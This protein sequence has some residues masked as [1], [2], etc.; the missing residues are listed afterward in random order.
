MS[1]NEKIEWLTCISIVITFILCIYIGISNMELFSDSPPT[2]LEI[3]LFGLLAFEIIVL[4]ISYIYKLINEKDK[5]I[6]LIWIV[7][8]I[9]AIVFSMVFENGIYSFNKEF[10]P[11]NVL[12]IILEIIMVLLYN[13]YFF[14]YFGKTRR[15]YV[16]LFTYNVAA[17]I[18]SVKTAG[19][20]Y[21]HHYY[22]AFFI[23]A[24]ILG[25]AE[26]ICINKLKKICL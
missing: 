8:P 26:W 11:L 23:L 1:K 19:I 5:V 25:Y 13:I 10:M 15:M 3:I 18:I 2:F 6:R 20:I 16:T 12:S 17:F 22:L 7:C 24:I 4:I 21:I 9:I 14:V